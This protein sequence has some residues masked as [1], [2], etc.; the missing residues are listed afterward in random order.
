VTGTYT[1]IT[2]DSG[3]T[4]VHYRDK[5]SGEDRALTTKW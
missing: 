4:H 1:R 2:R 3:G 5:E